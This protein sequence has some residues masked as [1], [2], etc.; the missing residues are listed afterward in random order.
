MIK[1]KFKVTTKGEPVIISLKA[2]KTLDGN[3]LIF[4]HIDINIAIIDN[5]GTVKILTYPKEE[6]N[7][8]VCISQDRMFDYLTKIGIMKFGSIKGGN[9]YG[10]IE[11][12]VNKSNT[13]I[14]PMHA[15]LYGIAKFLEEEKDYFSTVKDQQDMMADHYMNPSDEES[16]ELGEVPHKEK[17]GDLNGLGSYSRFYYGTMMWLKM[18]LQILI[19][20]I[21]CYAITSILLSSNIFKKLHKK[22][23]SKFFICSLCVGFHIGYIVF[24]LFNISNIPII[25]FGN[26]FLSYIFAGFFSSGSTYLLYNLIDDEGFKISL[27]KSGCYNQ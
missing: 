3:I 8:D 14:K 24:L 16:T 5:D 23:G 9:I 6:Y 11:G 19:F 12:T 20:S 18:G 7:D 17:Q 25:I 1:L 27:W 10:S 15:A 4:D 2:K 22:T 26:G 21:I 13:K